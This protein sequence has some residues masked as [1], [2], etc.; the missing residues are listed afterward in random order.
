MPLAALLALAAVLIHVE[1]LH[2]ATLP[3]GKADTTLAAR[4]RSAA[5]RLIGAA[6]ASDR[7]YERL[8]QLCDGIGHR[9]SGSTSLERAVAWAAAAM[10]DDG[11]ERVRLQP[12]SVPKWV[13]G[14]ESAEM[15]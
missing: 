6:L 13:R 1:V 2:A 15:V 12:V 9:L 7:A 3:R 11:L 5:E 8:S 10:R 4:Y 14:R